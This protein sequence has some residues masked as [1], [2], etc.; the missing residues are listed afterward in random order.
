MGLQGATSALTPPLPC[1]QRSSCHGLP[2]TPKV[3]V[4]AHWLS[5]GPAVLALA[6][7]SSPANHFLPRWAPASPR[8]SMAAPCRSMLLSLGFTL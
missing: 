4:S 5:L 3:H 7:G 1:T 2:P 8:S 6:L